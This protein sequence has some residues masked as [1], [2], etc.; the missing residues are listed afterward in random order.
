MEGCPSDTIEF[1][2]PY[3]DI[4]E[5]PIPGL[6]TKLKSNYPNPFN[7]TTTISFDLAEPGKA[8][9]SI[10]NIKGQLVKVLLE[11]NFAP[12]NYNVV[13]N[14]LDRNNQYVSSGVYFYRLETKN[15]VFTRRMMLLK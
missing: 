14:G 4:N 3:E 1:M 9:L 15:K 8:K 13:W 5:P 11:D 2:F 10:Y 12:G 6:I 7:P